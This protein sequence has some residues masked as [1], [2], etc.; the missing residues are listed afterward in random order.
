MRELTPAAITGAHTDRAAP[1][2]RKLNMGPSYQ[3]YRGRPAAVGGRE[4]LRQDASVNWRNL[5]SLIRGRDAAP[6]SG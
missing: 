3:A 5:Y 1:S 6:V 4:P 2:L